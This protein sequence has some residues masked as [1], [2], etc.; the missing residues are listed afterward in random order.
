MDANFNDSWGEYYVSGRLNGGGNT[1]SSCL[2]NYRL[3]TTEKQMIV[4]IN[5]RLSYPERFVHCELVFQWDGKRFVLLD[6]G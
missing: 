3:D 2:V 5:Q 6:G 4:E 1:D